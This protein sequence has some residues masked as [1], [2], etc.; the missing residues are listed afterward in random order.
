MSQIDDVEIDEEHPIPNL[1]VIDVWTVLKEGGCRMFVIIASPL[2]GD[3][4]SLER[5]MCKL[6]RYLAYL[7]SDECVERC[8]EANRRKH[9]RSSW[10]Y[11]RVIAFRIRAPGA[12]QAWVSTTTPR[13]SSIGR[14]PGANTLRR[15][16]QSRA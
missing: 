16:P 9:A 11:I 1:E 14:H 15:I 10:R 3:R 2:Q 6:E 12:Q 4:R 7:K 8:G 5:L 13:W